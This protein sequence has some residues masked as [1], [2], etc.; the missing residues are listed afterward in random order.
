MTTGT[1]GDGMTRYVCELHRESAAQH[2]GQVGP[3]LVFA[4]NSVYLSRRA[5]A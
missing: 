5:A 1:P 4:T 3:V 2:V